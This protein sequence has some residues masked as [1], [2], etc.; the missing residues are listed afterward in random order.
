MRFD[1]IGAPLSFIRGSGS[2]W[3][4]TSAHKAT[5]AASIF[6]VENAMTPATYVRWFEDL[7]VADVASVGGKTASLGELYSTLS[8]EGVKVPPRFRH[9][10]PSLSRR[11]DGGG[12]LGPATSAARR[13]E[14]GRRQ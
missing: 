9:H 4:T 5:T 13:P 1:R 3:V 8:G 11:P 7:G 10:R 12:R 2:T 14:C 6:K